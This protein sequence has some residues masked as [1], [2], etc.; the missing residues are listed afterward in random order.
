[1]RVLQLL[2]YREWN[3]DSEFIN[4]RYPGMV[5]LDGDVSIQF[6]LLLYLPSWGVADKSVGFGKE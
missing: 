6:L 1:M 4:R 3:T 5:R 2:A